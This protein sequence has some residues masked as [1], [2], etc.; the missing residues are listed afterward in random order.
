MRPQRSFTPAGRGPIYLE[1]DWATT[2]RYWRVQ[3]EPCEAT[4]AET[5]EIETLTERLAE[6]GYLDD[7]EWTDAIAAEAEAA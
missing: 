2:A 1:V 6:L 5:A 4:D 3:P 7:D